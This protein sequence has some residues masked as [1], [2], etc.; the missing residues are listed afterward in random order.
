MAQPL[1]IVKGFVVMGKLVG[2]GAREKK[3]SRTFHARSAAEAFKVEAMKTG[4]FA[5][6]SVREVIG[7]E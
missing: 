7:P 5:E 3:L 1:L 2:S 4:L 6:A